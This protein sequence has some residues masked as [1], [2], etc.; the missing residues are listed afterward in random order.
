ML[1]AHTGTPLETRSFPTSAE[2]IVRAI[3]W[4]SRHTAADADTLWVIEGAAS[5]GAILTGIVAAHGYPVAEAP[6]MNAKNR[7]GVGKSD[8]MHTFRIAAAARP[9]LVKELR[10]PR[11]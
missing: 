7:R 4:V 2:G 8:A 11:L 1:A 6:R 10:R 9:L 5:Y 3:S